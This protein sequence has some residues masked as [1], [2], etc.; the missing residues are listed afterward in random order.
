MHDFSDC[1]GY[2]D[3]LKKILQAEKDRAWLKNVKKST[4]EI[5]TVGY[6][7]SNQTARIGERTDEQVEHIGKST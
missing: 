4:F 2:A 7:V 6:Y 5:K 1:P 3:S